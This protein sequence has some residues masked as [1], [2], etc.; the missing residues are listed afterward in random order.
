MDNDDVL[1]VL[2]LDSS[3]DERFKN[4]EGR[5][6][7]IMCTIKR[8][9]WSNCKVSK[10]R[11]QDD[12]I[13][14]TAFRTRYRHF[15]FMVMPFGLT[16]TP[17]VFIDLMNR[18]CKL[19]LDKFIIVFID[20]ILIYS[21]T[22]ED[23]ENHLRLMLDLLRKEK[24]YAKFSKI[25]F[26]L[27]EVYFLGHVVNYDGIHVD[28][29]KIEAVKSWKAPMTPSEVRSFLGLNRYYRRFIENFSK[30]AKPLT[31]LTKKNQ[32]Y[33]WSEKQ[34]EAF[35]TL[36]DNLCNASILSLP[37]GVEDFV[38]YCD[39]SNQGL[40]YVLMQRDRR[41]LELFSDYECEIKYH[42][43]KANVVANALSRKER[44]N[45]RRVRAMATTIQSKVKGL[46]LA[47]QGE[48]FKDENVIAE[49]LNGGV[50]TKIMEEA[51][52]MRYSVHPGADKMYYDLRDMYWW[53]GGGTDISQKDEKPS[54]KRQNRTRDGKVCEDEAQS[55]SSQLREEKAKKNIT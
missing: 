3:I 55:K 22:K 21:K 9:A 4:L 24:L 36:K 27:Q 14:K 54:K 40:G 32:K 18:V 34:E 30:I 37:G 23:H 11:V 33:E 46:I 12:D 38:V 20:D 5:A 49:G 1:D 53:A 50:R 13:S 28:P 15:E 8:H 45:P 35:Q 26:W 48:A 17:A 52:K 41:W 39:A 6:W 44:V 51:H 16:N 7:R 25:E 43:G 47:A 2:G 29:S 31:S 19:Y 10:L 42:P